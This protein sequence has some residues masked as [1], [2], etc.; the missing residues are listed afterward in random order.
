VTFD[1]TAEILFN[2]FGAETGPIYL[3]LVAAVEGAIRGG[4]FQPGDR[5]PAQRSLGARLGVDFTTVTRAYAAAAERGLV[6]GAVGRGTFVRAQALEEERAIVDLGMI[7]PPQPLGVALNERLA[8]T[9]NQVLARSDPAT[10]LAYRTAPGTLQERLAGARW[11]EPVMGAVPPERVLVCAGAQAAIVA[12]LSVLVLPGGAVAVDALT[13][14]GL[15][16]AARQQGVRLVPVAADTEG[17]IPEALAEAPVAALYATATLQNPTTATMGEARRHALAGVIDARGLA[18]IEDDAYGRLPLAPRPALSRLVKGRA[19]YIATLSKALTPGLRTAFVAVSTPAD[20]ERMAEALRHGTM[21]AAPLMSAVAAAWI[22]DGTAEAVLHGVRTEAAA[23][24]AMARELLPSARGGPDGFH[25]WLDLPAG[26]DRRSFK[27]AAAARGLTVSPSDS[28]AVGE[29]VEG[30]RLTLGA[31]PN[32][33]VLATGLRAVA[34]LLAQ[35]ARG[36]SK[37][38]R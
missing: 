26:W 6:E 16:G 14:P 22:R 15:I 33:K 5:L 10:L 23:R 3:R 20:A 25:L 28:F 12:A 9:L 18:L 21:M 29:P 4:E 31:A 27:E 13:Y 36:A 24:M 17:L 35:P 8:E 32:R 11:I 2:R 34:A 7:L 38:T 1:P 30:V 19:I 37:S